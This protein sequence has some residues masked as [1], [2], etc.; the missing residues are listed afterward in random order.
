MMIRYIII[1]M[2]LFTVIYFNQLRLKSEDHAKMFVNSAF[3][4]PM[5]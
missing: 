1:A 3:S 5:F 4:L 2:L